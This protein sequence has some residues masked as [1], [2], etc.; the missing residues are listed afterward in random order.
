MRQVGRFS[1]TENTFGLKPTFS[2]S[3]FGA[4]LVQLRFIAL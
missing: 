2:L 4:M 1:R 3:N